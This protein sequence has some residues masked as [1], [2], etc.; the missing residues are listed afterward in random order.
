M[1]LRAICVFMLILFSVFA[2][3]GLLYF[4]ARWLGHVNAV[5]KGPA[6]TGRRVK[7]RL[8]RFLSRVL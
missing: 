8:G 6:A 5:Q 2:A 7:R 4:L 1:N 3:I